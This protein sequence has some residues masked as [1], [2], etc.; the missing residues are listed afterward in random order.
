MNT[1]IILHQQES[2]SGT[3][4]IEHQAFQFMSGPDVDSGLTY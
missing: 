3:D 2:N 1:K 4:H